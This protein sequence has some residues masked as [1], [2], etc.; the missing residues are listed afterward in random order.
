MKHIFINDN[1]F[2]NNNTIKLF[3]DDYFHIYRSLRKNKNEIIYAIYN[4]EK[5]V[6]KTISIDKKSVIYKIVERIKL[7]APEYQ[8][9]I[10]APLLKEKVMPFLIEKLTEVG[11]S[12]IFIYKFQFSVVNDINKNKISRYKKIAKLAS[13]QSGRFFIPKIDIVN[14]ILDLKNLL[15]NKNYN[16]KILLYENS[17]INILQYLKTLDK[18]QDKK[19]V[20]SSGPEGSF[21]NEE[22]NFFKKANFDFVNIGNYILR[23]ETAPVIL[24]SIFNNFFY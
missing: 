5:L 13:E 9:D 19:I 23:A 12:N 4:Y 1:N 2:L 10:I 21:H 20:F 7:N 6:L 16:K 3:D 22:L 17:R 8:I 18:T 24:T 11:I 15:K 14:N